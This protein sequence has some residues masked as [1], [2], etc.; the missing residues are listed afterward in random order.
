MNSSGS[1]TYFSASLSPG[2]TTTFG[3]PNGMYVGCM[4]T[5]RITRYR[6]SS[7]HPA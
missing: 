1:S 7:P 2:V 5:A 6:N 4:H 3:V